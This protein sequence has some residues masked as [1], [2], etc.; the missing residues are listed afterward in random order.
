MKA[1]EVKVLEAI[2]TYSSLYSG[3]AQFQLQVQCSTLTSDLRSINLNLI[4]GASST[5]ILQ[6]GY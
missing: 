1:L 6:V 2:T 5:N 3:R 4:L